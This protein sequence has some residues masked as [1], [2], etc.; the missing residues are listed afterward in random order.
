MQHAGR[1]PIRVLQPVET[2]RD[3][4]ACTP[5]LRRLLGLLLEPAHDDVALEPR[6]EIDD[7]LAVEVVDLVL[8]G[9]RQQALPPPAP[10]VCPR[11]RGSARSAE[12]RSMSMRTSGI[13]RQPSSC[14]RISDPERD[15]LGI[16]QH[17]RAAAARSSLAVSSTIRRRG[18]P[19]CTAARPTPGAAY[20]VSS[21]SS[22]SLRTSASMRSTGARDL[23]QDGVGQGDDRQ[24]RHGAEI[25]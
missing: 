18:T 3:A 1:E 12:G 9:G 5:H 13:D 19:T 25:R 7:Q 11:G 4:G 14:S 16:D 22:A 24:L 10:A 20:M 15:D 2:A 6:E 8:D 17:Q 23:A 21:M